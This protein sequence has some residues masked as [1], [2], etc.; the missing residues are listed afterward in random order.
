VTLEHS[1]LIFGDITGRERRK[2]GPLSPG[3]R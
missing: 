2:A 3:G 1:R